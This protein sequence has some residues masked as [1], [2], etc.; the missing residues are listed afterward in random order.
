MAE[1]M[2]KYERL[3]AAWNL[4]EGDRVAV[5]PLSIYII[6]YLASMTLKET[7]ENPEKLVQAAI[8]CDDIIGDCL[9]P[10]MTMFDHQSLLPKSGWDQT[11]LDWRLW[12]D[13]PPKG[14]IPSAYFDKAIIDDYETIKENGFAQFIFNKHIH[15]EV[16]HRS[17]DEFLYKE[18]EYPY[19]HAKAWRKYVDKTGVAIMMGARACIPFDLFLYYRTFENF[20]IDV[21]EKPELVKE[22]CE[23]VLDYEI[24]RAMRKAMI[25]G[26]GEVPGADTIFYALGYAGPPY[27]SPEIFDEFVWPTLKSGVDKI[28][29]RGF[30]VHIHFDADQTPVLETLSH[31]T[32][33][34]PKGKVMIDFE[35]TDMKKAKEII[36]D[37]VC[38]MG[39][40]PSAMMVYGAPEEIDACCKQLIEDCGKGGGFILGTECEVPWDAKRENVRAII[41]AAEKYG[42]FG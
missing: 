2:T 6:P 32:D 39:N 26:A 3:T 10:I 8:D 1:H 14:N 7:F 22:M 12:D 16:F 36:G 30:K 4:E 29:N 20:I 33:G 15:D 11:T 34:L 13:F 42:Q 40:V 9:H 25:M 17:I 31:L 35:K 18:F 38:L 21:F 23:L 19:R 27:I 37:K 41:Q 24:V 28:V 5:G